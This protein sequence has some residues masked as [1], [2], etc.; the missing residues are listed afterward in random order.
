MVGI[1][2]SR[3]QYK[4]CLYFDSVI[5]NSSTFFVVLQLSCLVLK[6]TLNTSAFQFSSGSNF[7]NF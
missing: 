6:I 1:Y 5:K 4:K 2:T 7:S 3:I